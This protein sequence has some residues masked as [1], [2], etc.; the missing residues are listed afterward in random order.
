MVRAWVSTGADVKMPPGMQ[1]AIRQ[2]CSSPSQ[3]LSQSQ[4]SRMGA[5]SPSPPRAP[6]WR[7]VFSKHGLSAVD[8]T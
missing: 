8:V 5:E 2:H 4:D 7:A 3:Q 1:S 6:K